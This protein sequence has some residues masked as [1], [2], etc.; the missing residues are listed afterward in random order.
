PFILLTLSYFFQALA[1][2]VLMAGMIY[3]VKHVMHLPE[4][5]MGLIFPIFLGSAIL[6]IPVWVKVGVRIGKIRAY[7]IGLGFLTVMLF[8]LFFASPNQTGLFYG[9]IFLLGI[10]FSSF[11]LFPFS[12][13]PDTIEY[14]EMRSG[15][16]REGIFSGS[17]AA[18]QKTAY[19]VGPSIVGF[20]LS[21]SGFIAHGVQP[22]SVDTGIRL[23]FCLFPA[24][25]MLLS[26]VPFFKYDLTEQRFAEIK[27]KIHGH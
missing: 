10:G 22:Q 11:Q 20:S 18:A 27:R 8:S 15:M 4:M 24:L 14:D 25:M 5:A 13:L 26:F 1:V 16:R 17:W 2:G 7:T 3:F 9:Q 6:F 12:M 21:L 19:S 23:V